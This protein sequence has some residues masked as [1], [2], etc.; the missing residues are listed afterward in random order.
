MGPS[1]GLYLPYLAVR[2]AVPRLPLLY[3]AVE[4]VDLYLAVEELEAGL[5]LACQMT[6]EAP[7][8]FLYGTW[9]DPLD[10]WE[11]PLS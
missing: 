9:G 4:E 10:T 3:L 1:R 5:H 6:M 2:D 8:P 11:E 7:S